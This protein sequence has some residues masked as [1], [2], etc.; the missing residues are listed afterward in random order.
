MS[1]ARPGIDFQ[2]DFDK[3]RDQACLATREQA[4][5]FK[6][7]HDGNG[8]MLIPGEIYGLPSLI[9]SAK[10]HY[11]ACDWVTFDQAKNPRLTLIRRTSTSSVRREAPCPF[12]VRRTRHYLSV[13]LPW[14]VWAIAMLEMCYS[15][16]S[17]IL[18]DCVSFTLIGFFR[19]HDI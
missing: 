2:A 3:A 16:L 14:F 5:N 19:R 18:G 11:Q 4:V 13:L 8:S 9:F 17:T 15:Q 12:F 7:D 6:A 1:Y 10:T